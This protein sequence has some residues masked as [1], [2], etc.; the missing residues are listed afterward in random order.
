[1]SKLNF[2]IRIVTFFEKK[3]NELRSSNSFGIPKDGRH[4]AYIVPLGS[5]LLGQTDTY[6]LI[7]LDENTQVLPF[8]GLPLKE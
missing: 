8:V 6:D 5:Y 7:T 4:V 2:S 1:M 3:K